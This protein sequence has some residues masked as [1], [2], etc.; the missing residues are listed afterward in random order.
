MHNG[1]PPPVAVVGGQLWFGVDDLLH[2]GMDHIDSDAA[3]YDVADHPTNGQVF[4]N[5]GLDPADGFYFGYDRDGSLRDGHITNDQETGQTSEIQEVDMVFGTGFSADEVNAI[6]VDPLN[7]IVF[8]GLWGQTDNTT[9]IL[10]VQYNPGTG[11]LTSPYNASTGLITDFNHVLI[12]DNSS[13]LVNGTTALT[14][15]IAMQYDMQNGNLY[16]VDQTNIYG[17]WHRY[18][19]D[20][21]A[22]QR[23]FRRQHD[24][25]GRRRQLAHAGA[26]LDRPVR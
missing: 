12:H 3:G 5:V 24:R 13:G 17:R 15:I 11:A 7:H 1:A 9:S 8:V 6:A 22:A 2:T 19:H 25:H 23:N 10:E 18:E 20:L 14:N 4:A 26:A 21:G 16:Y